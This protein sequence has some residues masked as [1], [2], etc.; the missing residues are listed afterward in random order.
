MAITLG[1]HRMELTILVKW[2]GPHIISIKPKNT[3]SLT[4]WGCLS[5]MH[6]ICVV[7]VTKVLSQHK[8]SSELDSG[9]DVLSA[10]LHGC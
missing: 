4:Q 1:Q 10:L 7:A 6:G 3:E 5:L 2:R 9:L 8:C